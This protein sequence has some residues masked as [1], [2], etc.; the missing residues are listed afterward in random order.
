MVVVVRVQRGLELGAV[1]A[2]F[3]ARGGEGGG[4][5]LYLFGGEVEAVAGVRVVQPV[6]DGGRVVAAV[7]EGVAAAEGAPEGF[8]AVF[9]DADVA[10]GQVVAVVVAAGREGGAQGGLCGG[11]VGQVDVDVG[12]AAAGVG[13]QPGDDVAAQGFALALQAVAAVDAQAVVLWCLVV[14]VCRCAVF[15]PPPRPSP[16]EGTGRGL[17][18]LWALQRKRRR[19]CALGTVEAGCGWCQGVVAMSWVNTSCGVG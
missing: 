9:G 4:D 19:R 18:L 1:V 3:V 16:L 5:A 8:G 14:R 12:E 7:G 17:R 15:T 13:V 10:R 6:V 11:G 2:A